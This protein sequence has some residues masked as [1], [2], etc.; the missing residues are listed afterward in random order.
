MIPDAYA[1]SER[2]AALSCPIAILSG[3]ADEVVDHSS[4]AKR[5]HDAV[6]GSTLDV[7]AGTGHMTHHADPARVVRAIDLVSGT[8]QPGEILHQHASAA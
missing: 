7:F 3:D 4:Q 6:P 8:S 2:Y 1:M 5:L